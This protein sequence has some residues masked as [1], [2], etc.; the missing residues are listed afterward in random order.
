[1]SKNEEVSIYTES[2]PG[3]KAEVPI[4]HHAPPNGSRRFNAGVTPGSE[5]RDNFAAKKADQVSCPKTKD[6]ATALYGGSECLEAPGSRFE[7][8][9]CSEFRGWASGV[10]LE[11][12]R[13]K[14][15]WGDRQESK[16]AMGK[17]GDRGESTK[18]FDHPTGWLVFDKKSLPTK[19]APTGP[20]PGP[21][22]STLDISAPGQ[23]DRPFES[24]FSAQFA[25]PSDAD[26]APPPCTAA[27]KVDLNRQN[28]VLGNWSPDYQ[29]ENR[30]NLVA[31]SSAV[32]VTPVRNDA[33]WI[34]PDIVDLNPPR[35]TYSDCFANPPCSIRASIRPRHADP[36]AG[37]RIPRPPAASEYKENFAPNAAKTQAAPAGLARTIPIEAEPCS[38]ESSPSEFLSSYAMAHPRPTAPPQKTKEVRP[39]ISPQQILQMGPLPELKTLQQ[40]SFPWKKPFKTV[41]EG[42]P[43]MKESVGG[44]SSGEQGDYLTTY[45]KFHCNKE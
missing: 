2:Y 41:D 42:M 6:Y 43:A 5:Y 12:R 13:A 25:A 10:N 33:V 35:T 18:F 22:V 9:Y 38:V 34:G 7:S 36:F 15:K 11:P 16:K 28:F 40:E 37:P 30:S 21:P 4:L 29:T 23:P 45:I 27:L 39:Y 1:M 17:W 20:R 24:E 8:A 26:L 31:H 32:R 19:V 14:G 3:Y 44:L